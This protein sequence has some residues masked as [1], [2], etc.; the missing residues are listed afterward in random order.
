MSFDNFTKLL[1]LTI[2]KE[3]DSY[4]FGADSS[5]EEYEP[6]HQRESKKKRKEQEKMKPQPFHGMAPSPEHQ[7]GISNILKQNYDDPDTQE[8]ETA[9][10][11]SWQSVN[12]ASANALQRQISKLKTQQ[13]MM[14]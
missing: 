4:S 11:A 3:E 12:T 9:P 7:S 14:Q 6:P 10:D 2:L 13:G 8:I 1:L 5:G